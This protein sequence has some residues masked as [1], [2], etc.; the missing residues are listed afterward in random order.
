MADK[1][2][3][4]H[5]AAVVELKRG[6]N[7]YRAFEHA[8]ETIQALADHDKTLADLQQKIDAARNDYDTQRKQYQGELKR[9]AQVVAQAKQAAADVAD[10]DRKQATDFMD[11]ARKEA[12]GIIDAAK[13]KQA[14]AETGAA[15]AEA[16]RD[17]ADTLIAAKRKELSDLNAK[18]LQAQAQIKQILGAN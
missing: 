6:L 9:L 12:D 13:R 15:D 16:R 2:P 10:A 11:A 4:S 18:I 5:A 14:A 3:Y 7:T 8:Q 17:R 1:E